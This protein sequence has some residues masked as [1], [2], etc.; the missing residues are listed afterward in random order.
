VKTS[1]R[2][3]VCESSCGGANIFRIEYEEVVRGLR[4]KD[5]LLGEC[6]VFEGAVSIEVVGRDVE[7]D[8]DLR[9]EL[10]G[11]FELKAGDFE[12]DQVSAVLWL[13]R[14][15]TGTPML[16]PTSVGKPASSR[17]S[18]TRDVVVVLPLE[19]VMARDLPWRKRAASSSSP[20]TGRPKL[21]ACTSSGVSRGTPGLTTIRS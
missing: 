20:M 18:P 3:H 11:R 4:G 6:V 2:V 16:P 19:P 8:G 1:K 14:A 17:I 21:R 10:L 12:T 13:M 15:I 9:M 7:D 5:A